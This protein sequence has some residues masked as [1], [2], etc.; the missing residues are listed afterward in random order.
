[1]ERE[2]DVIVNPGSPSFGWVSSD[3]KPSVINCSALHR[4]NK[5]P[6]RS[7]SASGRTPNGRAH[8]GVVSIYS[9]TEAW[10]ALSHAASAMTQPIPLPTAYC[11]IGVLWLETTGDD[12]DVDIYG[13]I[14][15]GSERGT[16]DRDCAT[17][18][19][20]SGRTTQVCAGMT[21]PIYL[22]TSDL[23]GLETDV[24]QDVLVA[25]TFRLSSGGSSL[26]LQVSAN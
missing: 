24:T 8:N 1:M 2:L 7:Y 20:A 26:V 25:A 10:A 23:Y 15:R 9:N 6:S 18:L 4:G 13:V 3:E 17:A 22:Q 11:A 12:V 21:A 19:S 5:Y 16:G 14:S